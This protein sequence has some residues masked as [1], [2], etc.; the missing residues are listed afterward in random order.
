MRDVAHDQ[1]VGAGHLSEEA[2]P[3]EPQAV[4]QPGVGDENTE[5]RFEFGQVEAEFGPRDPSGASR[6]DDRRFWSAA[7][8]A[9]AKAFDAFAAEIEAGSQ[10]HQT[11]YVNAGTTLHLLK[12]QS[13]IEG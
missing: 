8:A 2:P 3:K 1:H 10:P 11:G 5:D 13:P 6:D 12:V 9:N 7:L 4:A